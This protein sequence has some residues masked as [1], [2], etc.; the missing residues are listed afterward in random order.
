MAIDER[1]GRIVAEMKSADWR[2]DRRFG[3]A[4]GDDRPPRERPV[5]HREAATR[6]QAEIQRNLCQTRP[7]HQS[8]SNPKSGIMKSCQGLVQDDNARVAVTPEQIIFVAEVANEANDTR[9][10]KQQLTSRRPWSS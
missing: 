9:Q 4:A 1:V 6:P 7:G 10:V 8:S 5:Y 3:S 2:K